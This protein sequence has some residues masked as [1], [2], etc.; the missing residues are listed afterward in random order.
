MNVQTGGRQG[1]AGQNWIRGRFDF[2]QRPS[3][4]MMKFRGKLK[5]CAVTTHIRCR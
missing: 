2:Q 5:A 4:A 1:D 3:Q